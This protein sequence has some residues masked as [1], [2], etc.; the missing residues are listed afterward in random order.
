MGNWWLAASSGQ[1]AHSCIMSHAHV[2]GETSNHPD[3]PGPLRP[4]FGPLQLLTFSKTKITFDREEIS[5]HLWDSGKYDGEADGDWENCVRSQDSYFERDWGIIFLSI[6][7]LVSFSI[8]VSIFHIVWLDSFWTS[9]IYVYTHVYINLY[10]YLHIFIRTRCKMWESC[11]A[12]FCFPPNIFLFISSK[13]RQVPC[14]FPLKCVL[15][16]D[17]CLGRGQRYL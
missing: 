1:H 10:L 14:L 9:L 17:F 6:M 2:F 5:N 15:W 11:F 8:N 13:F 12:L 16:E 4:R 3:D 7:F